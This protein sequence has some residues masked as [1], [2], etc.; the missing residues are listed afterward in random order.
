M[1][2]KCEIV[3]ILKN[4]AFPELIKIGKTQRHDV[5]ERMNELY[6][7]GV[8]F[9]FECLW[10][11]EVDNCS[12]IEN[13]LHNA[14]SDFRVNIN[15]EFFKLSPEKVI[16]ILKKLS[17]K[18]VTPQIN[19]AIDK[20]ITIEEKNSAGIYKKEYKKRRPNLNFTEMNIPNGAELIYTYDNNIKVNVISDQRVKYNNEICSLSGLTKELL[21]VAYYVG[22]CRYWTYNGKNLDEIYEETYPYAEE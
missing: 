11:G 18:E 7:T 8:P 22:P 13:I 19:E 9:P 21:N 16:P 1:G 17:T 5:Q 20:N 12:E 14:F 15:R 3:Y 6:S 2:D 4:E 10:A